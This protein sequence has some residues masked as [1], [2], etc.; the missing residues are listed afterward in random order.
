VVIH[1]VK[2]LGLGDLGSIRAAHDGVVHA[3]A[4]KAEGVR[5]PQFRI[6]AERAGLRI[7]VHR[8]HAEIARDL[9]HG[10]GA[11]RSF[12]VDQQFAAFGVDQFARDARCFL[13]LALG[14]A[15][16]HFDLPTGEPTRG[17]DLFHFRHHGVARRGAELRHATRQD[18]GHA[19]L[20][21]FVFC[22]S[23]HRSG[24]NSDGRG[25]GALEQRAAVEMLLT[26]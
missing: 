23:H 19:D 2:A 20:D 25:R 11:G 1:L 24:E 18:C 4:G 13:W 26:R 12:R 3:L 9:M 16:H 21:R 7:G 10:E 17:V 14:V 6:G 22:A 5:Q 15:D 8:Q